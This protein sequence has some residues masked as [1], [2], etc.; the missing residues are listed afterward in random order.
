MRRSNRSLGDP[1]I[2][3][4]GGVPP[5][6]NDWALVHIQKDVRNTYEPPSHVIRLLADK[7]V[8]LSENKAFRHYI[9]KSYVNWREKRL[10]TAFCMTPGLNTK[11]LE[12]SMACLRG[13]E[14]VN[15]RLLVEK[16]TPKEEELKRDARWFSQ[17][18]PQ[19]RIRRQIQEQTSAEYHKLF[20]PESTMVASNVQLLK[21]IHQFQTLEKYGT[22]TKTAFMVLDTSSWCKSFQVENTRLLVKDTMGSHWGY[23]GLCGFM[24][25]FEKSNR[26]Y[27]NETGECTVVG[28]HPKAKHKIF[29]GAEGLHQYT[30]QALYSMHISAGLKAIGARA[31]YILCSDDARICGV[32][33]HTLTDA[34]IFSEMH[35]IQAKLIK[36]LVSVG[37]KVNRSELYITRD[38]FSFNKILMYKTVKLTQ[39]LKK[40]S[41]IRSTQDLMIPCLEEYLGNIM[42]GGYSAAGVDVHPSTAYL[43]SYVQATALVVT[44]YPRFSDIE[45]ITLLSWSSET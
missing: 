16:C 39:A 41:K 8:A 1:K 28:A 14:E 35:R 7:A 2:A 31:Y 25:L 19:E 36:Y 11:S 23:E 4:L 40:C 33:D 38:L 44:E 13:I 15:E 29:T 9:E 22:A 43:V 12:H 34:E 18:T 10:L 37:F 32:F 6:T 42:S 17:S 20:Q 21:R 26:Y 24:S 27:L 45:V 5:T 3:A 30:W